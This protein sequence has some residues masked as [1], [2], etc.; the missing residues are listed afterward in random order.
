MNCKDIT[1]QF[2][3]QQSQRRRETRHCSF[4]FLI[5]SHTQNWLQYSYVLPKN[6]GLSFDAIIIVP[7]WCDTGTSMWC[8]I[9]A[10]RTYA[11]KSMSMIFFHLHYCSLLSIADVTCLYIMIILA[12][13]L[14]H[15]SSQCCRIPTSFHFFGL[16]WSLPKSSVATN[17]HF[18]LDKITIC[19]PTS[20][21]QP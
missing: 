1:S 17:F 15:M 19:R 21:F 2:T 9:V 8:L 16:R 12:W 6:L 14:M 10:K 11:L 4:M 3:Q 7:T 5:D 13:F 20:M 18:S